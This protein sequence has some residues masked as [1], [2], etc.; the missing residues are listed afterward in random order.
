MG[1]R[2]MVANQ[3]VNLALSVMTTPVRPADQHF[4]FKQRWAQIGGPNNYTALAEKTVNVVN[5]HQG[6]AINPW[7]NYPY[8]TNTA[9]KQATDA[10]HKLDMKFS[11]YNTMRELSNLGWCLR[12]WLVASR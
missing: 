11:T 10:C 4:R 9:M 5:M 2:D 7:I 1:K 3:V 6:N 12:H 8:L